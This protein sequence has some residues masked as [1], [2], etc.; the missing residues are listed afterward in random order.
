MRAS[1]LILA[2]QS[3]IIRPDGNRVL[4]K[5]RASFPPEH[6]DIAKSLR[7]DDNRPMQRS[8]ESSGNC[9]YDDRRRSVIS[10]V[11]PLGRLVW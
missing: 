2:H 4:G 11:I 9:S 6:G 5:I 7:W 3:P 8:G 10:S 1:D